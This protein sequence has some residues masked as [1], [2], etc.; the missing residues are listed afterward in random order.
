VPRARDRTRCRRATWPRALLGTPACRCRESAVRSRSPWATFA[1]NPRIRQKGGVARFFEPIASAPFDDAAAT[2][3]E[4]LR[5][6]LSPQLWLTRSI[7]SHEASQRTRRK[8]RLSDGCS[9]SSATASPPPRR[10]FRAGRVSS[11]SFRAR[12]RL[13]LRT[14]QRPP[15]P[16]VAFA[17]RLDSTARIVDALE[18]RLRAGSAC[19]WNLAR[20]LRARGWRRAPPARR[21]DRLARTSELEA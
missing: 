4:S 7:R 17:A 18:A 11:S 9:S 19:V 6:A 3:T 21:I 1:T 15:E 8:L 20:A 13:L 14:R 10:T 12:W 2:R 5:A 16:A